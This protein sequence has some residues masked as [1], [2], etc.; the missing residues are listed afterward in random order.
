MR[1][2]K[3]QTLKWSPRDVYLLKIWHKDPCITVHDLARAMGRTYWS[4]AC[5]A[6]RL[7]LK[8]FDISPEELE[9]FKKGGEN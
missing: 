4:V 9:L 8:K 2:R 1:S 6:S 5:K 3:R 7:G